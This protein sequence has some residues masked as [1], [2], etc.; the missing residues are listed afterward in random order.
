MIK[1]E[2]ESH[3]STPEDQ[4]IKE[5]VTFK[6]IADMECFYVPYFR[7]QS[8][9][10]GLFW[11]PASV[12]VTKHGQKKY[13]DG[14]TLDSRHKEKQIKEFLD[15]RSWEK[16]HAQPVATS[17]TYYPHGMA[18]VQAPASMDEVASDHLPF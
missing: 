1:F 2:F 3:E 13:C 8:K 9:D 4:Y 5:I 7:K 10:G 17:G 18:Q 14:F 15:S 11:S 12:G 6:F 16:N